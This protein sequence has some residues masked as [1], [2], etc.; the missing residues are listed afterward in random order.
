LESTGCLEG[1]CWRASAPL[2]PL[3]AR[4]PGA[5]VQWP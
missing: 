3:A 4:A 1:L 2:R 5:V